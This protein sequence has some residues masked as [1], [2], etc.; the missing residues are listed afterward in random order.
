MITHLSVTQVN[1]YLRCPKQWEY[2]YVE[3]KIYPP[4]AR[5][6]QGRAFHRAEADGFTKKLGFKRG[7]KTSDLKFLFA[8][9]FDTEVKESEPIYEE[10]ESHGKLL[11]EGVK[12]VEVYGKSK[13]RYIYP[14]HVEMPFKIEFANAKFTF[15]GYIDLIDVRNRLIDLKLQKR[16]ISENQMLTDFQMTSYWVAFRHV[17]GFN[18]SFLGWDLVLIQKKIKYER[19]PCKRDNRYQRNFLETVA[20][21]AKAI[22]SGLFY[23]KTDSFLCSPEWCGY[24]DICMK[25]KV[26]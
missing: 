2:R 13:G 19:I 10:G 23:P 12:S 24:W 17:F 26:K 7:Y 20:G 11:D 14:K 21:V 5:L 6:C 22:K 8:E 4:K 16:G 3:G 9:Y 15:I 1:M 18:P 25:G